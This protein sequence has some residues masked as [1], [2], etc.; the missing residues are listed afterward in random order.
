MKYFCF[1]TAT[2]QFALVFQDLV[3]IC[4]NSGSITLTTS[5]YSAILHLGL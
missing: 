1:L 4:L 5:G 2:V 3:E